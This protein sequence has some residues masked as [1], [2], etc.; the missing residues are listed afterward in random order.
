MIDAGFIALLMLILCGGMFIQ[1]AAGFAGGLFIIPAMTW[2]GYKIPEA[3]CALLVAMIPQNTM[4]G[5]VHGNIY[6]QRTGRV[7]IRPEGYIAKPVDPE[8]LT[9]LIKELL[10]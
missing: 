3:Q 5:D 8:K 10:S 2:V 4:Y 9:D 6:Y 1:S 7:P